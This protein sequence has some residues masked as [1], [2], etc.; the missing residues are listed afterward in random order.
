M[1]GVSSRMFTIVTHS[2]RLFRDT[3][4][5]DI[6]DETDIHPFTQRKKFKHVAQVNISTLRYQVFVLATKQS[7]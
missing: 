4:P 5:T 7:L 3:Q 1:S 2:K 6:L